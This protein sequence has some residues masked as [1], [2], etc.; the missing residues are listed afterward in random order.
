MNPLTTQLYPSLLRHAAV[1]LSGHT[2]AAA[3]Q[4]ADL[5]HMAVERLCSRPPAQIREHPA[6]FT[7]L[8]R[9]IMQRT[10]IDEL[11]RMSTAR[12]PDLCS[13]ALLEEAKDI[14]ANSPATSR[15]ALHEALALLE[16]RDPSAAELICLHWLEGRTGVEL[17]AIFNVS[18]V[19]ISR[20]LS[21]ALAA[22]RDTCETAD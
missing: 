17:A 4:P 10:L 5:L 6:E 12:R 8:M 15:N 22:L 1:L 13:A 14:P 19:T 16:S 20:R 18:T 2:A 7:G 3:M 21:A 11:R 9:T